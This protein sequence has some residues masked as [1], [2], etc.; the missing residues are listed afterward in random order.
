M[1]QADPPPSRRPDTAGSRRGRRRSQRTET[2]SPITSPRRSGAGN[3]R[4]V[5]VEKP[6]K[7]VAKALQAVRVVGAPTTLADRRA[8]AVVERIFVDLEGEAGAEGGDLLGIRL[9][10]LGRKQKILL[11][12]VPQAAEARPGRRAAG[13]TGVRVGDEHVDDLEPKDLGHLS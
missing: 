5:L 4:D 3:G 9:Q 13:W 1:R 10:A 6:A 11:G 8:S 7:V 12:R 2:S